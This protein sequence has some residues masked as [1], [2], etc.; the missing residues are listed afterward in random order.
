VLG[1]SFLLVLVNS[2]LYL[3]LVEALAGR[4][5]QAARPVGLVALVF[6][7]NVVYGLVRIAQVDAQQADAATLKIGVAEANVG[8]FEKQARG[9]RDRNKKLD[10]LRGNIL[11]H[12]LLA[13]D[14]EKQG[15]DLIIEAESSFIPSPAE[16]VR[17]KRNDL[18]AV[19]AG[20]GR[21]AWELRDTTW[22]GPQRVER[23]MA[24]VNGM[25]AAREDHLFAVGPGGFILRNEGGDWTPEPSKV[26]VDLHAVWAGEVSP[27]LRH[28]DGVLVAAAAV[29]DNGT[30][31]LRNAKDDWRAWDTG[32][33]ATLRGVG[34]N[35]AQRIVAVGDGGTALLWDGTSW[36]P[37][38]TP[39]RQTLRSVW[40]NDDG[41]AVAVGD[42]GVVLTRRAATW[43]EAPISGAGRLHG[44]TYGEDTWWAVGDKGAIWRRTGRDWKSVSSPTKETL[45]AVAVNG[46]GEVLVVGRKATLLR[47][48]LGSASFKTVP[49]PRG[50][51]D[52]YAV[53]GVPFTAAHAFGRDSRY[54]YQSQAPL[55]DYGDDVLAAVDGISEVLARDTR[56]RSHE[57]NTPLRGFKTPI[58]MGL[59]T[60]EPKDPDVPAL[61]GRDFRR[62]YNSAVL[63]DG[64]GRVLGRYDKNYLLVFGEYIPFGDIF[65][66]FY[67]W[68]PE[69][70]H[71]T[72]G[73]DVDTFAFK[74]H[75]LG[76]IVCY[77]DILPEFTRKLAGK[78]PHVIINVTNDAWFGDTSEPYLHLALSIFR[79]VENRLW[80]IRSTNTGISAYV[81]A[82]GRIVAS[83]RMED[84]EMLVVDVPMLRSSTL[85]RSWGDLFAWT[86]LIVFAVLAVAALRA[87]KSRQRKLA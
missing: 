38:K 20:S 73:E 77:E 5:K 53:A 58:L 66:Q 18:F 8:I 1:L 22:S 11:K 76:V 41:E 56:P 14:L 3:G 80:L 84:P 60:Y 27:V 81:D 74:G 29:G 36:K 32:T 10:M 82:V 69:A 12:Q 13:A 83:T 65:P 25:V 39:T 51:G 49:A 4:W 23:S 28:V 45:R 7:I 68:L 67:Q 24:S 2:G 47:A 78:D 48:E 42:G 9:L 26:E 15:V 72:P 64:D 70:S 50:A 37:E 43:T 57:W 40:M 79:S 61:K 46:R 62:T 55:P 6:I 85:Y 44:V 71:F 17:Y 33:N 59:L 35:G 75:K 52:L 21:D 87:R 31:L 19:V 16:M 63:M 86:D 30:A 34:G 54:I